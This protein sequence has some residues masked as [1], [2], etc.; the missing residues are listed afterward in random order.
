MTLV[1][2][3]LGLKKSGKTTVVESLVKELKSRGYSVGTVKSMV[4]STFSIDVEGKDTWRHKQAGA[5]FVISL[6][7]VE[8][9]FIQRT[10]SRLDL[11]G[12]MDMVP[13][14]TDILVCEGL[15]DGSKGIKKVVCIKDPTMLEETWKVRHIKEGVVAISGIIAND[16]PADMGWPV[17]NCLDRDQLA[18]LVEMLGL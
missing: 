15:E 5:D 6:S 12:I 10:S 7:E 2:S 8:S 16:P 11:E 17:V 4:H 1:I 18:G 13:E 3:V 14:C 9:V